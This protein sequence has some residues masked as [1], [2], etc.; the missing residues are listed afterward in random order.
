MERQDYVWRSSI[1]NDCFVFKPV[2]RTDDLN[3]PVYSNKLL[4]F[5]NIYYN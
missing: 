1:S 5:S 2:M 4:T 3:V